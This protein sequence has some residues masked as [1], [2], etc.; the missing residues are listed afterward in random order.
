MLYSKVSIEVSE[1]CDS[2]ERSKEDYTNNIQ[3]HNEDIRNNNAKSD[4]KQVDNNNNNVQNNENS[5]QENTCNRS[6]A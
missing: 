6:L 5:E 1:R 2:C 3:M 4:N